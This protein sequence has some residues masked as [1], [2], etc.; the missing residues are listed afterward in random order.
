M[1][2]LESEDPGPTRSLRKIKQRQYFT[3][4]TLLEISSIISRLKYVGWLHL[5]HI[6][7]NKPN[8]GY[9]KN[10]HAL[11]NGHGYCTFN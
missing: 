9:A 1:K 11:M 6:L 3:Y 2:A 7:S 8:M 10:Q 5:S 4:G